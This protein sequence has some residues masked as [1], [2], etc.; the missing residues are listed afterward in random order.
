[1]INILTSGLIGLIEKELLKHEPE[2]QEFVIHQLSKSATMLTDY[3]SGKISE[4]ASNKL[5]SLN[6]G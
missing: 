5:K 3:I 4:V 1:M 6:Q 2:I